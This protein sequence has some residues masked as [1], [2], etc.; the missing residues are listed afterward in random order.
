MSLHQQS[1]STKWNTA[2]NSYLQAAQNAAA[3][4]TFKIAIRVGMTRE[5]RE[6]LKQELLIDL[7]EQAPHYDPAKGSLGTFTGVVSKNRATELLDRYIK[8]KKRLTFVSMVAANDEGEEPSS[9]LDNGGV[10]PLWAVD[11]DL[12]GL[13]MALHDLDKAVQCMNT[14]QQALY[15]LLLSEGDMASACRAYTGSTATFYRRVSELKTHLRMFGIR[16]DA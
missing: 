4:R 9:L 7:L 10:T 16:S 15:E 5:E 14:D 6:D 12:F 8:D 3:T 1:G 11:D 2:Q 13:S